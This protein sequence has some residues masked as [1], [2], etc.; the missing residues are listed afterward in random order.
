MKLLV[1][2]DVH[3]DLK[4]LEAIIRRH[5]DVDMHIDAGD[6]CLPETAIARF[7]MAGVKGNN[8][9]GS[10]LPLMRTIEV[11][12]LRIFLSHGHIEHVKFSLERLAVKAGLHEAELA[13]FGHTHKKHLSTINGITL[14]NPGAVS[15]KG[16]SYAI[17]ENGQVT[18]HDAH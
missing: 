15:G 5:P 2:S 6:I 10:T 9:F 7:P 11:G 14:L 16:G 18:F 4:T 1:T 17:Y 12:D 3:G 13:I 8:D